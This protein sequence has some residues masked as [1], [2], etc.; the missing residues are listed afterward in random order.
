MRF[1]PSASGQLKFWLAIKTL[2]AFYDYVLE[3]GDL[4]TDVEIILLGAVKAKLIVAWHYTSVPY[5]ER[6]HSN[7]KFW[8]MLGYIKHTGW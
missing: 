2:D 8:K 3:R 6:P 4:E 1:E 5:L 7:S